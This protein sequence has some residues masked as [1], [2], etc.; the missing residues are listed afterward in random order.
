[1]RAARNAEIVPQG[2][3][4]R[5]LWGRNL[6]GCRDRNRV[7]RRLRQAMR[8]PNLQRQGKLHDVSTGLPHDL[9]GRLLR[10]MGNTSDL[11]AGLPYN[12]WRRQVPGQRE[13]RQLQ[14]RLPQLVRRWI[15]SAMGDAQE[16]PS[17]LPRLRRRDLRQTLWRDVLELPSRLRQVCI[18]QWLYDQLPVP[19]LRRVLVRSGA[20]QARPVVL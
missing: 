4:R 18:Q 17:R 10:S 9:R 16:L 7:P 5:R 15:L 13:S 14:R 6:R 11:S 12:L 2:L 20:V 19:D 8:R 3:P 1:M